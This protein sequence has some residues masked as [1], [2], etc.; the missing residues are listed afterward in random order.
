M[1]KTRTEIDEEKVSLPLKSNS[2]VQQST[3][4]ALNKNN[5]KINFQT[6]KEGDLC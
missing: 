5:S 2:I 4:D 3:Y 1:V 6:L